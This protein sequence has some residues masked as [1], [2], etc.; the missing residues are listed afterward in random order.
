M[1]QNVESSN[2]FFKFYR[3]ESKIVFEVTAKTPY[4]LEQEETCWL[5]GSEFKM[6]KR[7]KSL[8]LMRY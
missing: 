1:A 4:T 7:K 8:R 5:L 2:H 6:E 3:F